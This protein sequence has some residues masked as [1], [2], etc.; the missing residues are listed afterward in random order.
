MTHPISD[1]YCKSSHT[2]KEL[3]NI[4]ISNFEEISNIYN[5]ALVF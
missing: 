1:Y 3:S 5:N 4:N 2:I